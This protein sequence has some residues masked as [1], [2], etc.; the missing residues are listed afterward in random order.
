M[1]L[2]LN[3]SDYDVLQGVSKE[4]GFD[5]DQLSNMYFAESSGD[6]NAVNDLG[7]TGGFQFGVDTGKEY[8]LIGEGFDYRK[9]LRRSAH[10]AVKMTRANLKDTVTTAS[11]SSWSLSKKYSKLGINSEL[12][13]YLTTRTV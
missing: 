3:P 5:F 11:G 13:G 10:A 6:K 9:D 8:G 7:Y 1:G 2:N 12:A 4:T